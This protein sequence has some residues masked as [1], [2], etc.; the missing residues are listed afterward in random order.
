MLRGWRG[1][2][3]GKKQSTS[4]KLLLFQDT[5]PITK[6]I[7]ELKKQPRIASCGNSSKEKKVNHMYVRSA[8]P[9]YLSQ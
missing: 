2:G 6:A 4:R 3:K 7:K 8:L 1:K 5:Q 9:Q